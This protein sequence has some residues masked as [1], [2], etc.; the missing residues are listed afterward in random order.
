MDLE[1]RHLRT[2]IDHIDRDLPTD[3]PPAWA[4]PAVEPSHVAPW[5]DHPRALETFGP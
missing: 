4:M 2:T 1:L 3:G 5:T